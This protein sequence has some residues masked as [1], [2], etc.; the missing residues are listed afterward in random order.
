MT[1]IKMHKF[2]IF[3]M[4]FG[5][6]VVSS[7]PDKFPFFAYLIIS[8]LV[9]C[10]YYYIFTFLIKMLKKLL[11][12]EKKTISYEFMGSNLS[13]NTK[14]TLNY[15]KKSSNPKFIRSDKEEDLSFNFSQRYCNQISKYENK[16]YNKAQ[17][18]TKS[19]S[20]G[21]FDID[22]VIQLHEDAVKCFYEFQE[23]CFNK[24][25]GGKIYFEDMWL[26]CHNSRNECFSYIENIETTLNELKSNYETQKSYYENIKKVKNEIKRVLN[27]KEEVI[28]KELYKQFLPLKATDIC[29]AINDLKEEGFLSSEKYLNTRKLI[30]VKYN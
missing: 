15:Y 19:I 20:H 29:I 23:F 3:C 28:Q 10:T 13:E 4:F 2:F 6:C 11:A 12:S 8:F 7:F 16:I 17:L 27:E 24:S 18:A 22:E 1:F 9:G 26:H 14:K 25:Q 5:M 21:N 30:K